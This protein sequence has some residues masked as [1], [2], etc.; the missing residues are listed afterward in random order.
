MASSTVPVARGPRGGDMP[1]FGRRS[2]RV[3]ALAPR[4]KVR[5]SSCGG[6]RVLRPPHKRLCPQHKPG[7]LARDLRECSHAT[8]ATLKEGYAT[9]ATSGGHAGATPPRA[10]ASGCPTASLQT[11]CPRAP[12]APQRAP[13]GLPTP[14]ARHVAGPRKRVGRAN[15]GASNRRTVVIP[16]EV[17][18]ARPCPPLAPRAGSRVE[19]R[20]PRDHVKQRQTLSTL[21]FFVVGLWAP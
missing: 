1:T 2:T 10:R 7:S 5:S 14:P 20:L 18:P 19:Q 3:P 12:P 9:A 16:H 13:S 21:P 4:G 15:V 11:P 8:Q 17:P 6:S